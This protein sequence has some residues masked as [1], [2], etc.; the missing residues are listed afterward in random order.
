MATRTFN[1]GS[2][3]LNIAGLFVN[4]AETIAI[5]NQ[6]ISETFSY[7]LTTGT[8]ADQADRLYYARRTVSSGT[9]DDIDLAS[10]SLTDIYGNAL[11]FARIKGIY[12]HNRSTTAAEILSV[13]AG[14]NPLINW[15]MASGDGVKV[16]A[17][18]VFFIFAP[19]AT[20]Y[21]VTAATGDIL[22][23]AAASGSPSYDILILGASA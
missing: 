6:S 20:A 16:R 19:D 18:G 11:T 12:I 2:I 3:Q 22:E 10:G 9:P 23:I 21:A 14:S 7:S 15:V 5:A 1:N 17:G 4:T 13:G 8:G